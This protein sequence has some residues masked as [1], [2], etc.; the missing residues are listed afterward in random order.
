MLNWL[1]LLKLILSIF[2][3]V[4]KHVADKKLIS[5]AEKAQLA[6]QLLAEAENVDRAFKARLAQRM[7]DAGGVP[8]EE[9]DRFRRD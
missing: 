6:D 2:S 1:A 7:R 9:P 8:D 3:T 5:Q 4:S